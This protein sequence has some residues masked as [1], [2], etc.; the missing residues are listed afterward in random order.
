MS[1][2]FDP[3]HKWLGIP[4]K[5]QPPNHY[6]LLGVELLESDADVIENAADQRMRH[7]RAF[8]NGPHQA[9]S[10]RLLNEIAGAKVCLLDPGQKARYDAQFAQANEDQELRLVPDEHELAAAAA[11]V[12]TTTPSVSGARATRASRAKNPLH[13][14]IKVV[15][16]GVAGIAIGIV[17][18]GFLREDWDM[19]GIAKAVRGS[20]K[21]QQNTDDPLANANNDTP[22]VVTP[23]VVTPPV[24]TP[25]VTVPNN[26]K[27]QDPEKKTL[28]NVAAVKKLSPLV[29]EVEVSSFTWERGAAELNLG[30]AKDSFFTLSMI[31][32]YFLGNGERLSIALKEDQQAFLGG[33]AAQPLIGKA[34]RVRTP[35]RAWF[36]DQV[37]TVSWKRGDGPVQLIHKDDGFAVLSQVQGCFLDDQQAVE[38][39]LDPQ[40]GYWFIHGR[41]NFLS[42]GQA[43]IYRFKTPGKFRAKVT[44]IAWPGSQ[45]QPLIPVTDG[46]C[47]ISAISGAF[48]GYGESLN[49][50]VKEGTWHA[51]GSSQQPT[52]NGK[53]IQIEFNT[54]EMLTFAP[55]KPELKLATTQP[56]VVEPMAPEDPKGPPPAEEVLAAAREKL[57]DR[58]SE[59]DPLKLLAAA[60]EKM[61]AAERYVLL[62]AAMDA[63]LAR[64][65]TTA[66]QRVI[67]RTNE[68]FEIDAFAVTSNT[69]R[70]LR[71]AVT[72]AEGNRALATATMQH[73]DLA[74]TKGNK[75]ALLPLAELSVA[76]AR[77]AE[78]PDLVRRATLKL[79]EARK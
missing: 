73:F 49:A 55:G 15:A 27:K 75:E 33:S 67:D 39:Y 24:V 4:L 63:A 11:P 68:K 29:G 25:P 43:H 9:E 64:G 12:F 61:P 26:K 74:V 48:K 47:Y 22:P 71:D 77:K 31:A 53:F 72:T 1:S 7:I 62:T 32:G 44:E 52:T 65:D 42:G 37:E 50:V 41:T 8:Q 58:L 36:E 76:A 2:G 57:R 45:Q 51:W 13:E 5:D 21:P 46:L 78:D 60:A 28:P 56:M 17:V 40:S 10:Q 38:V 16:G 18:L 54:P 59:T 14:I 34:T 35:Y 30:S 66:A 23:P 79:I 70:K 19:F 6:R 3:Y 69:L 20:G